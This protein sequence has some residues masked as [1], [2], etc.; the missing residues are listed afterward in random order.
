[1]T[2][3]YFM[4][5]AIELAKEACKNDEVPIGAV[6]VR[7]N[8][9]IARAYNKREKTHNAIAHAEI[10]AIEKAC[11]K[12]KDFRLCGCTM[13]VTLEPCVMCMGAILNSRI[14]R[15]VFGASQGKENILSAEEINDRAE[16]NHKTIITGGVL[17]E[18]TGG[19]VTAYF[20]DKR[21][22]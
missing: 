5:K 12:L 22:K 16:L 17:A 18:E 13:Y 7:D 8:K 14:D 4:K 15:L 2:D 10:L 1:M 11:K 19:L 3:E 21:K 6:V 9:I 20:R